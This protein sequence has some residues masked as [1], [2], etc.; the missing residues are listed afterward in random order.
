[1]Y[2]SV[3][4]IQHIIQVNM[5]AQSEENSQESARKDSSLE[6]VDKEDYSP[7]TAALPDPIV[8]PSDHIEEFIDV[9]SLPDHLKDL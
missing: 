7:K 4:V 3:T 9:G 1:M 6:I 5:E 2:K 8:Y